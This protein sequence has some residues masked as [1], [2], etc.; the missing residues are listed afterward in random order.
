LASSL[1]SAKTLALL[2]TRQ[3]QLN[4]ARMELA[5]ALRTRSDENERMR[6]RLGELPSSNLSR[7]IGQ[8]VGMERLRETIRRVALSDAPVLI[9][10]ETGTGK[11]LV[12]RAIHDQ[13]LRREKPFLAINCAAMS[14]SL[15]EAE[16]FGAERGA[17]TNAATS[18]EGLFEAAHGGSL[19]LDEVGDMSTAM[20]VALLRVLETGEVRR[21][22]ATKSRKVDVRIIAASHKS[23]E[24]QV[25]KNLFRAD[26]RYRLEVVKLEVPALRE[27]LED[28]PELAVALLSDAERRYALPARRLSAET[29]EA[30]KRRNW[31]GN[32]RQLRHVLASAALLAVGRE[33]TPD[34]LPPENPSVLP[35]Q[36][37]GTVVAVSSFGQNEPNEQVLAI[38]KALTE[39]SGNRSQAAKLLGISRA[40]FYRYIELLGIDPKAS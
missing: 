16:L 30:L 10:G 8:S 2:E 31:S 40:T 33:I 11:E 9:H 27:H 29:L 19:L 13:S 23:L 17:Y 37:Q 7:L 24:E 18:R 12:A 5:Q 1:L 4:Q 36:A 34:C 22:G 25:A 38:R 39:A 6:E 20:Q 14:E 21:I 3:E 35:A 15:V 32:V 28:L 26:L